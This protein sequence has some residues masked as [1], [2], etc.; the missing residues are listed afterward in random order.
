MSKEK[1]VSAVQGYIFIDKRKLDKT[2]CLKIEFKLKM[3]NIYGYVINFESK[4]T[5]IIFFRE[6]LKGNF[7]YIGI[8]KKPSHNLLRRK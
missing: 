2:S 8:F 6:F 4:Y 1:H 3:R 5:C 7:L